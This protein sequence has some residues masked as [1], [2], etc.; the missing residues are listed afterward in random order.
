MTPKMLVKRMLQNSAVRNRFRLCLYF[1]VD[2]W[3]SITSERPPLVAPR[4]MRFN[5]T[6]TY[7]SLAKHGLSLLVQHCRLQPHHNVLDVGCGS[8][9]MAL[10]LFDYLRTGTYEGF[11]IVPSWITWCQEHITRKNPRFRFTFVDVYSKHYNST[12]KLTSDTLNFPYGDALFD[13]VMLMSVFTHM[14]PAGIHNYI[15]EISRVMKT[16]GNAFITTF[17]LNEE[18]RQAIKDQRT[19]LPFAH[20]L[21]DCF[22]MD[23]V[24]P[25]TAIAIPEDQMMA[26]FSEAGLQV[27]S[28]TR[29]S[30]AGRSGPENLHDN[31]VLHKL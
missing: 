2:A 30:W 24:F 8:G 1:P 10:P 3:E 29:G 15:R 6:R 11:D 19:A 13:C 9:S 4:G 31:V 16:G 25:E 14:L 17:L 7:L 20:R 22:V 18:S 26:W 21:G 28:V 5:D 27:T 23:N 12:G